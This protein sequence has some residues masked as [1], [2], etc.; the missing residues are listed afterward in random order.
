MAVK[1]Q[2]L[3][4]LTELVGE[5]SPIDAAEVL[6]GLRSLSTDERASLLQ[7]INRGDGATAG[8]VLVAAARAAHNDNARATLRVAFG[9]GREEEVLFRDVL[10]MLDLVMDGQEPAIPESPPIGDPDF[11]ESPDGPGPLP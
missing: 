11:V 3:T 8:N 4:Y 7:A 2:L 5:R 9:A 1:A 6:R 10:T